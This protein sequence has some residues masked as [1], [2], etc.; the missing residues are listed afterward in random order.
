MTRL[1]MVEK[2]KDKTGVT[3]DTAR[4]TLEQA[5]WDMLDAI[6]RL[7]RAK[8]NG[9]APQD[10]PDSQTAEAD[11]EPK[12]RQPRRQSSGEMGDKVA[13]AVRWIGNLIRKGEQSHVEVYRKDE[14]LLSLSLTSAVLLMLL[15]WWIP[16]ILVALGLFT[17]YKFK[18]SGG[19]A[20][21]RIVNSAAEKASGKAQEFK[22]R[23][24]EDDEA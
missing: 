4:E 10:A 2:I 24:S 5:N 16:L 20:A 19:A 13:T 11:E 14:K 21:S 22:H 23:F 3:Y 12:K 7:E 18:F 9:E 17:G 1:E 8:M 6:V 15:S